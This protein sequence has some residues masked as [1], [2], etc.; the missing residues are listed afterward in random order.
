LRRYGGSWAE[1]RRRQRFE[2]DQ[3]IGISKTVLGIWGNARAV[4]LFRRKKKLNAS[5]FL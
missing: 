2:T 3:N 1:G 5:D 4:L